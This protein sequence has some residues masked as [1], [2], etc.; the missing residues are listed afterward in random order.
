MEE[1]SLISLPRVVRILCLA[2]I[3]VEP[4]FHQ[5][6]AAESTPR[7]LAQQGK[8]L[9]E[10]GEL[11]GS[12]ASLRAASE[13]LGFTTPRDTELVDFLGLHLYNLGVRFNNTGDAPHALECFTL[14][15]EAGGPNGH[16]RDAVFRQSLGQA[17]LDVAAFLMA[18][19]RADIALTAYGALRGIL[20][21]DHRVQIGLGNAYLARGEYQEAMTAYRQ[22]DL[23][24]PDSAAVAIG[25]ARSALGL[26]KSA[27]A[28]ENLDL[29]DK[30]ADWLGRA[31]AL[32]GSSSATQRELASALILLSQA[33]GRSGDVAVSSQSA[34]AAEKALSRAVALEPQS[35][36]ARIDLASLLLR[37]RR[38]PESIAVLTDAIELLDR[39]LA[40][41]PADRNA[42]AWRD[43]R[44]SCIQN[45]AIAS[46]NVAVD[47]INRAEF[48]EVEKDLAGVCDLS[49]SW[50]ENCRSLRQAGA[51]RQTALR[52]MVDAQQRILAVDPD[53][54]NALV[55]LGDLYA[56]LGQ[57]EKANVY[58]GRL[59]R[60]NRTAEIEERI[61]D[62]APPGNLVEHRQPVEIP[63]SRVEIRFYGSP[64]GPDFET[65]VKAAWLRVTT[66]LGPESIRGPLLVTLYPNRRAF[67]ER[68]GY[69]VGGMVKGNYSPGQVSLFARP[70]QTTVE[71]VSVLTH[72]ISHHAVEKLS[73]GN[74]PRWL[75]EGIARW[76]E[77]D[78]SVIDRGRVRLR[79][80][81]DSVRTLKSLDE[82]MDRYW[83]D[84]AEIQDGL[85]IS[86]LAV[87]ELARRQGTAGL[88]RILSALA[89]TDADIDP[90]RRL[91]GALRLV[92]GA[93][94]DELDAA[95]RSALLAT[96]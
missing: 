50:K 92:V 90:A 52:E 13:K 6:S 73:G 47:A 9:F 74:A 58:Y 71:W 64:P 45:R 54:A 63:M 44:S 88:K 14:A 81:G 41:S 23:L 20:P 4:A 93:G 69:R 83:N 46:F 43:A 21:G 91:D 18:S 84:P 67:R 16:I 28:G 51:A 48:E 7:Q 5:A 76:V 31:G 25:L 24:Q 68:A 79:L 32:D 75:N 38:Y 89:S 62:V 40:R 35:V 53:S 80:Q 42:G 72:E 15:L 33:A 55:S 11:A 22:A 66:A 65:A 86:L 60:A 49:A 56:G 37:S 39:M 82:T 34:L 30:A 77:G 10:K 85:D 96:R 70:S 94:I 2:A 17:T 26:A 95:W 8:E 78:S 59:D 27:A 19:G 57:Y 12:L 29:L 3:L 87:E 1:P 36:W 61:A